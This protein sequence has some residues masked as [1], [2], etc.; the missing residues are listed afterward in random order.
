M[1]IF[2]CHVSGSSDCVKLL[3]AM[4][5]CLEAYDIYYGTPLHVACSKE[6]T[7]C[8]KVLLN[9]GERQCK[10]GMGK[11]VL[12][13]Y[14]GWDLNGKVTAVLFWQN[15]VLMHGLLVNSS[16]LDIY[17]FFFLQK[18]SVAKR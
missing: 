4:D 7:D 13:V 9:A 18:A 11:L 15:C 8:V 5:A 1:T 6:H 14:I 12:S 10:D 2:A 16:F 3:I 17:I